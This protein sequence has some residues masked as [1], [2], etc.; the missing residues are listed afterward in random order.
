MRGR[1]TT[2]IP[3][4]DS[5]DRCATAS[6]SSSTSSR[7]SCARIAGSS[8]PSATVARRVARAA[9]LQ[10]E[11]QGGP[12][13]DLDPARLDGSAGFE[14]RVLDLLERRGRQ[15]ALSLGACIVPPASRGRSP[16][17]TDRSALR[18]TT[19]TRPCSTVRR[20][21]RRDRRRRAGPIAAGTRPPGPRS[22][23]AG[24]R[25][26]SCPASARPDSPSSSIGSAP[27][28]ARGERDRRRSPPSGGCRRR[29]RASSP[30]SR[31]S[32]RGTSPAASPHGPARP[33]AGS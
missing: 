17:S 10:H 22:A 26:R 24:S 3:G 13:A 16:T 29:R 27:P 8:E 6:T 19:S 33:A 14:P 28:P 20:R 23:S 1:R 11:R 7:S 15:M 30:T 25:C 18:P 2:A 5:R 12:N 31:R 4:A 9:R 32:A 21:R